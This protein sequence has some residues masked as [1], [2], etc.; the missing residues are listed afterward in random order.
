M[1][2]GGVFIVLVSFYTPHKHI[3]CTYRTSGETI[4]DISYNEK[5]FK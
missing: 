2:G 3:V 4:E 1:V 5:I